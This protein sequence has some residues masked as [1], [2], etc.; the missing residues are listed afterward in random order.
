MSENILNTLLFELY[1]N[2]KFQSAAY[3][4]LNHIRINKNNV[5]R[6]L[7]VAF[8]AANTLLIKKV[9]NSGIILDDEYRTL[10]SDPIIF[11]NRKDADGNYLL[12][13]IPKSVY[14]PQD[15][16]SIFEKLDREKIDLILHK[17]YPISEQYLSFIKGEE[18]IDLFLKVLAGI[19]KLT[20]RALVYAS[21]SNNPILVKAV[22][23]RG[24]NANERF[25]YLFPET[26]YAV[27]CRTATKKNNLATLDFL[28]SAENCF[29][30][31]NVLLEHVVSKECFSLLEKHDADVR[32]YIEKLEAS[33]QRLL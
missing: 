7:R 19:E 26:C 16:S 8:E 30:D 2:N 27:A 32:S 1:H 12:D 9:A 5:V 22:L 15:L 25:R 10:I 20:A 14:T 11:S 21:Y 33:S 13:H 6:I 23:E 3:V 17:K 28:L 29:L 18:N 4:A 24:V 31:R